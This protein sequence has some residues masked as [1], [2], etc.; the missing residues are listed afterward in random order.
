MLPY[1]TANHII[2]LKN[3]IGTLWCGRGSAAKRANDLGIYTETDKCCREHDQCNESMVT[4]ITDILAVE[5]NLIRIT[6]SKTLTYYNLPLRMGN[7]VNMEF[8]TIQISRGETIFF[9]NT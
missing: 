8:A 4:S 7:L 1:L 9:I 6:L 5:Y 3:E 2:F